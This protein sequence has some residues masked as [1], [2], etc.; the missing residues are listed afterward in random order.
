MLVPDPAKR[1][2]SMDEVLALL[3]PPAVTAPPAPVL[4][5]PATPI[6]APAMK[7]GHLAAQSPLQFDLLAASLSKV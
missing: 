1:A 4:P 2:R 5:P 3:D 6:P 7:G